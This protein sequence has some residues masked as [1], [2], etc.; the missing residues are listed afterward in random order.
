MVRG[1]PTSC[2]DSAVLVTEDDRVRSL[3][4]TD[5]LVDVDRTVIV[6]RVRGVRTPTGCFENLF[7]CEGT[8]DRCRQQQFEKCSDVVL[9]E[10]PRFGEGE[11]TV[12]GE[13]S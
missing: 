3:Q 1:T 5:E 12:H 8:V 9:G 4:P 11:R 13:L 10:F 7:R 6:I 2:D